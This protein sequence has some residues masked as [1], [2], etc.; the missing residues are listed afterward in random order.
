MLIR[1]SYS[2]GRLIT[3]DLL[4]L[5]SSYSALFKLKILFT[6]V[7]KQAT[8]KR[9]STVMSLP[10]QL[11]F[12]VQVLVCKVRIGLINKVSIWGFNV[13]LG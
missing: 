3:V 4:V 10:P 7:S 6:F 13:Q 5:T 1:K 8:L 12:P 11:V 9:R 2:R